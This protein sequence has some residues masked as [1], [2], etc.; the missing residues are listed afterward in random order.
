[1]FRRVVP[2]QRVHPPAA[3]M[4]GLFDLLEERNR[5]EPRANAAGFQ[6]GP[7]ELLIKNNTGGALSSSFGVVAIGD[8]V[9]N[10]TDGEEAFN[11][12]NLFEGDTPSAGARIAIVQEPLSANAI[13][14]A[15]IA[16]V[17]TVK[18]NVIDAA[19]THAG[20]TTST[21]ELDTANAGPAEILWKES[22]T[23]SKWAKVLLSGGNSVGIDGAEVIDLDYVS[24]VCITRNSGVI[25]NVTAEHR[26]IRLLG[27][28][29]TDE[30]YCTT[31]D[32]D[33]C[34]VTPCNGLGCDEGITW[35]RQI[36][37]TI[38]GTG[39]NIDGVYTLTWTDS[40]AMPTLIGQGYS[41][42]T[43]CETVF[44]DQP[45]YFAA[46]CV[47]GAINFHVYFG[48]V[49]YNDFGIVPDC[50][51]LYATGTLTNS[52]FPHI[53]PASDECWRNTTITWTITE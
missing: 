39:Q 26:T 1:M 32:D 25:T 6:S 17:T 37:V 18:L 50:E 53:P 16:G 19:H 48:T 42:E 22:G 20:P 21:S 14:R 34:P 7:I 44:G 38:S 13:G 51:P 5:K 43:V 40:V 8:V 11:R 31:G 45:L 4:N 35:P 27:K 28:L 9:I 2:G 33:C 23:G 15:I 46:Q 12:Q 24:K 36:T 49:A 29:L 47:F 30:T 41:L 3:A 10:R 52:E